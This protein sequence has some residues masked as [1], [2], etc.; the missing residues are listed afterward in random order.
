MPQKLDNN[1]LY[2]CVRRLPKYMG[3]LL[4]ES[5]G[6][7]VG[8]GYIR[9][10]IAKEDIADVDVFAPS[11]EQAV[12]W[13][14]ELAAEQGDRRT[15][16]TE[17]AVTVCG[18]QLPIQFIHR[19]VFDSP[20]ALI[21]SFDFTISCAAIWWDAEKKCWDSLCDARFYTDLAAKRLIYRSP[22]RVEETG[23]SML[24][25]LKY[26]QRGYRIPL[27]SLGAVIA[28]LNTGVEGSERLVE[29]AEAKVL[30]GLLREVD[31][32]VDANH[33][34]HL[35]SGSELLQKLEQGEE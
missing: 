33:A 29:A 17:N 11:K 26:Y 12:K 25:V 18:G 1:D 10:C 28:R 6:M 9:A 5:P 24:R 8:G 21:N 7:M 15:H 16:S 22:I 3:R 20:A 30:T 34:C 4:Q 23:G 13:A 35:P 2:W 31:P 27:D 32:L 19:W 14:E